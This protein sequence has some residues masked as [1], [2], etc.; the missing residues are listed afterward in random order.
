MIMIAKQLAQL[1]SLA[2][3]VNQSGTLAL[4]R[5][6]VCSFAVFLCMCG[7]EARRTCG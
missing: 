7:K 4:L 2:L 6:A 1:T 5:E 3:F